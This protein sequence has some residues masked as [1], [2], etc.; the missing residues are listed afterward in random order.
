MVLGLG[1][2]V[3]YVLCDKEVWYYVLAQLRYDLLAKTP[4]VGE[5][6]RGFLRISPEFKFQIAGEINK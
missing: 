4:R 3:L 5:N 1:C 2:C 6:W